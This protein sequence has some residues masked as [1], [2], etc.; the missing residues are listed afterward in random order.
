[1]DRVVRETFSTEETPEL[2][3]KKVPDMRSSGGRLCS[4][5]GRACATARRSFLTT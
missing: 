4:G 3:G 2:K 1:M 5:E